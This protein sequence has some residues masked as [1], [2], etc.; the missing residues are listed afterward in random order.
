[1]DHKCCGLDVSEEGVIDLTDSTVTVCRVRVDGVELTN[2]YYNAE[3]CTAING[4]G[5]LYVSYQSG[6]RPL[7]DTFAREDGP[8]ALDSLGQTEGAGSC[9]LE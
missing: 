5:L 7:I 4:N 9:R 8:V 3:N 1:M 2:G 6:G